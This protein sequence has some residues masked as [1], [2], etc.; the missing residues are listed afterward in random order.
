M[1]KLRIG[2]TC[3]D[4]V[5]FFFLN[6]VKSLLEC[7]EGITYFGGINLSVEHHPANPSSGLSSMFLCPPFCEERIASLNQG[8]VF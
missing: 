1:R 7:T 4:S 3:S 8:I 6:L 5:I 2:S